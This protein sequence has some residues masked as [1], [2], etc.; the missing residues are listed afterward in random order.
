[1]PTKTVD[2]DMDV[3]ALLQALAS[4]ASFDRTLQKQS[5]AQKKRI[6]GLKHKLNSNMA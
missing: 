3:E 2:A 5:E 6:E 4:S 1:M